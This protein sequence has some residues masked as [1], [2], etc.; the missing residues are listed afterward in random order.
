MN[1]DIQILIFDLN[2]R[3]QKMPGKVFKKNMI[4]TI[5]CIDG[6]VSCICLM[7]KGNMLNG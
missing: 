7:L 5:I 4:K 2:L 6:I 1:P 3:K